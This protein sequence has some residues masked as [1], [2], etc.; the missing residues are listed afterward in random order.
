MA[1]SDF[2]HSDDMGL[3]QVND[4]TV[5]EE[6]DEWIDSGLLNADGKPIGLYRQ[7]EPL[8]FFVFE[9]GKPSVKS[10]GDSL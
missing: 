6:R 4:V 2:V 8:G 3:V 9:D 1:R 7:R 10:R 5:F